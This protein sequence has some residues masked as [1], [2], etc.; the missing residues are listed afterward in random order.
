[1][2]IYDKWC[3]WRYKYYLTHYSWSLDEDFDVLL[4]NVQVESIYLPQ[5]KNEDEITILKV[6]IKTVEN[7]RTKILLYKEDEAVTVG[8][9][10]IFLIH[11]TPYGLTSTNALY[12]S[13]GKTKY[14]YISSG[15]LTGESAIRLKQHISDSNYVIFGEHG[16]KYKSAVYLE[17]YFE[18]AKHLVM[19]SHNLF[20]KQENMKQF[21]DNG[22]TI[23][24]HPADIIYFK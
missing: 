9:Y 5:P 22:C 14:T 7:Y 11:S 10:S 6:L 1:M 4:S 21:L 8:K 16:Q 20:L 2:L 19:H 17:E 15:L 13:D 18:Y 23:S 24:S 3:F 12:F